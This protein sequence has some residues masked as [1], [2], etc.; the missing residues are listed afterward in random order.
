VAI[1][2]ADLGLGLQNAGD[3]SGAVED[4]GAARCSLQDGNTSENQGAHD[5]L[6]PLQYAETGNAQRY[7]NRVKSNADKRALPRYLIDRNGRFVRKD[8]PVLAG[9]W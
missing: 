6:D 3:T 5:A 1:D 4:G 7:L 2:F 8:S 9:I